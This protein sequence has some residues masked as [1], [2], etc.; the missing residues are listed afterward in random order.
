MWKKKSGK[1][2]PDG[3]ATP[4]F[5]ELHKNKEVGTPKI[6]GAIIWIAATLTI[7]VLAALSTLF[8]NS[9]TG[10]LNFLSRSQ[11]WIPF[12]TLLMGAFVGLIDDLL[13]IGGSRDHIAGGLSLKKRLFIVFC[14]GIAVGLWFYFKLDVHSIGI[15]RFG[16]FYIGWL[17]IPLVALV[18]IA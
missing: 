15:P 14:I 12:A 1:V 3:T 5:N 8:P 13:E 10:K 9:T 7:C 2:A 16:D 6:G 4:I 11:T 17:I 18:M